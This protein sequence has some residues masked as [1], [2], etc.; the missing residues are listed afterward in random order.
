MNKNLLIFVSILLGI[1]YC[2]PKE[3]SQIINLVGYELTLPSSMFATEGLNH[4]AIV[5]FKD[6]TRMIYTFV[7]ETTKE[8]LY[9]DGI[10]PDF[11]IAAKTNIE[12]FNNIFGGGLPKAKLTSINNLRAST[13]EHEGETPGPNP[14]WV[15]FVNG[16]FDTPAAY[17]EVSA[18]SVK[19]GNL[20][21]LRSI[22]YS[23]REVRINKK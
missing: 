1:T 11:D 10:V 3:E 2:S 5:Q 19:K 14:M 12:N 17:Y 20:E 4:R 21:T 22:V 15:S 7:T 6:P 9:K 8:E 13:L 18:W 16:D 23:F